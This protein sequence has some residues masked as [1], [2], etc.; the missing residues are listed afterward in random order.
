MV[1]LVH[2][3]LASA[4][5]VLPDQTARELAEDA[6]QTARQGLAMA[7]EAIRLQRLLDEAHIPNVVLKGAALAR[8]AYGSLAFKHSKDIDLLVPPERAAAALELLACEGY[9]IRPPTQRLGEAQRLAVIR[10]GKDFELIHRHTMQ[11][12]ELHWRTTL[13]PYLLEGIDAKSP[14]QEVGVTGSLGI[15][16]LAAEE[17]FAYLC[18]HGALHAWSRLKWLADLNALLAAM[19]EEEMTHLF[20]YAQEQGVGLCAGQALLLCQRLLELKLPAALQAELESSRRLGRLVAIALDCMTGPDP[21]REVLDRRFSA[22]RFALLPF[23]LGRGWRYLAAQCRVALVGLNDV[24]RYPLPPSL[25][26][27]YP[28]LRLPLWLCRQAHHMAGAVRWSQRKSMIA[29]LR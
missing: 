3:A 7:A 18:A 23:L 5:V 29:R 24:V 14:A 22:M 8:L 13:N 16:T 15:R 2:H 26:F 9:A 17:H 1:G 28:I 21:E 19:D 25:Y 6:K 20:R 10:F 27:L 12:V 4:R 11:Q